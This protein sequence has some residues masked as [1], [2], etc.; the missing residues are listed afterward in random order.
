MNI[1][2]Q[3]AALFDAYQRQTLLITG[4]DKNGTSNV[5]EQ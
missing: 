5:I 1:S 3:I 2:E 4:T